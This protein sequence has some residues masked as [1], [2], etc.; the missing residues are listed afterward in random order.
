MSNGSSL[1]K[2]SSNLLGR[3]NAIFELLQQ[4]GCIV[5]ERDA[6]LCFV[7]KSRSKSQGYIHEIGEIGVLHWWNQPSFGDFAALLKL[8][9]C[10]DPLV[11]ICGR[12]HDN[13]MMN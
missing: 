8:L 2:G 6:T 5:V 4:G 10:S 1:A 13:Y 12:R 11:K 3:P 7:Q 9:V